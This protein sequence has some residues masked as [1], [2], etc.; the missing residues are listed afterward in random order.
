MPNATNANETNAV[1]FYHAL[2]SLH[3]GSGANPG[4]I[5]LPIQR[6][7]H[8][9]WPAI[10]ASALKGVFRDHCR[11][12]LMQ[13]NGQHETCKQADSDDKITNAFGRPLLA[14]DAEDKAGCLSFTDARILAFPVRSMFGVFAWVS[15]PAVLQRFARDL[16]L[17]GY[18]PAEPWNLN[19]NANQILVGPTCKL[20]D[21]ARTSIIL[22]DHPFTPATLPPALLASL[23]A[24][25]LCDAATHP[26]LGEQFAVV[27]DD[28]FNQFAEH[29]TEVQMRIALD[30]DTKTVRKGAL[31]SQEFL[32]T[33]TLLYSLALLTA[34]RPSSGGAMAFLKESIGGEGGCVLQIGGDET[35][36]KGFCRVRLHSK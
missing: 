19:V 31:F 23:S 32:P 26:L 3:A 17:A 14:Q 12:R 25:P 24:L 22:E 11:N 10:P 33:E 21:T 9:K 27:G 28:A 18:P 7:R 16:K 30:Y 8:T 6:E 35:T 1:L 20:K 36:G 5:D 15:C 13:S 4:V 29:A 34:S 2:T